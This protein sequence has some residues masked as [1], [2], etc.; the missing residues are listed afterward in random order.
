MIFAQKSNVT[1]RKQRIHASIGAT[2]EKQWHKPGRL[3]QING[4]PYFKIQILA[5]KK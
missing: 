4:D 3:C 2:V 1:D 5:S